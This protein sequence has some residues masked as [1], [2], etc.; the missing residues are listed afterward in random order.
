M[1]EDSRDKIEANGGALYL[2]TDPLQIMPG[3]VT[4]GEVE[5]QT[6]FE[7]V[8]I[9]LKTI[10]DNNKIIEDRMNDDISLVANFKDKG[11]V[12]VTGCS[13]AGI[14][15]IVKQTIEMTGVKR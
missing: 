15:N 8:G 12:I 6:D 1:Q 5:R 11:M 2:T 14:V 4:T 10:T 9:A 3:L 7:E 13:H